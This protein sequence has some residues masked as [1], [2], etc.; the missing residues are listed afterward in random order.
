[1]PGYGALWANRPFRALWIGTLAIRLG[2]QIGI[3]ALTWLVLRTTGS[4]TKIG[5]VLALYAVGDMV[6]SPLAGVLLD[7]WSR[8]RLLN[9]NVLFQGLI[10]V[11]LAILFWTH[12]L[13]FVLLLVI[14]W[15]AGALSP[16]SYLGR[17]I[18][19]PNV[20]REN[21][22]ETANT[23][24]QFN[25]NMVTLLGPALGGI[26]VGMAGIFMTLMV[27]ALTCFVYVFCLMSIPTPLFQSAHPH[28]PLSFVLDVLVGWRF[29]RTV[30]A[31]VDDG[32]CDILL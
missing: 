29:L 7:R 25:M 16:V 14:V 9:A 6:A 4:G 32:S 10:F 21:M 27:T 1:M 12:R 17:M 23:A 19:L 8:K 26:L 20:V 24:M 5:I 13:P 15:G 2:S 11:I 22:W 3:I 18:I 28:Q 31:F 30:P